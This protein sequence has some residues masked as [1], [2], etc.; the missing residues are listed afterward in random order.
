MSI[1]EDIKAF[2]G[3][4]RDTIY[5]D[6]QGLHLPEVFPFSIRFEGQYERRDTHCLMSLFPNGASLDRKLDLVSALNEFFK[7]RASC[8]CTPFFNNSGFIIVRN[9][10]DLRCVKVFETV[11]QMLL[12]Q[13]NNGKSILRSYSEVEE[14]IAILEHQTAILTREQE[15]FCF[16]KCA[17][18][19]R[20]EGYNVFMGSKSICIVHSS[21]F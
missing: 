1:R 19:F 8:D 6:N 15:L 20:T 5:R 21:L 3:P 14:K 10:D 13:I 18:Y 11:K 9:D 2:F 16:S 17:E 7:F 4:L 12:P